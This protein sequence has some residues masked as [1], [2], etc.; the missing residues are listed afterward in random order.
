MK[1]PETVAGRSATVREADCDDGAES[2]E[3][4]EPG[5]RAPSGS[6]CGDESRRDAKLGRG[7]KS[8]DGSQDPGRKA[9]FRHGPAKT[10][11][12]PKLCETSCAEDDD[13][14]QLRDQG[15]DVHLN[16]ILTGLEGPTHA[17]RA[18]NLA[19]SSP[20]H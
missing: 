1:L 13:Q 2:A 14:A 4:N 19:R 5:K 16:A 6:A 9:E 15:A 17:K 7:Y 20:A 11:A 3:E 18:R 8:R 10:S 12:I